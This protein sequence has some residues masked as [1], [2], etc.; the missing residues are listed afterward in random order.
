VGTAVDPEADQGAD[1]KGH[2]EPGLPRAQR[3]DDDRAGKGGQRDRQFVEIRLARLDTV[4][5]PDWLARH[6]SDR[7][8]L[9]RNVCKGLL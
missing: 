6:S 8:L 7:P 5:L 4:S 9:I 3:L 2:Q 1:D